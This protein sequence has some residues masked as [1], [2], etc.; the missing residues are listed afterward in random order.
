MV[1]NQSNLYNI[2]I[3]ITGFLFFILLNINASGLE[4]YSLNV[5]RLINPK[6]I[7]E[8]KPCLSWKLAACKQSENGLFQEAWQVIVSSS[9]Q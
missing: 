7:D 4:A 9:A 6:C 1:R 5:E 3:F 2:S 8:L